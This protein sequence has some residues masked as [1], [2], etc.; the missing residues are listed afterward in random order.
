MPKTTL[1]LIAVVAL[2]GALVGCGDSRTIHGPGDK[3]L[4]VTIPSDVEVRQGAGQA[5]TIQ[6]D[7]HNFAGPI[8]VTVGN[9]PDGTSLDEQTK[10]VE[11]DQAVFM[12]S[13]D[14]DA[15]L[16][17]DHAVTVDIQAPHGMTYQGS[18]PLTVT[19]P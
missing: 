14:S 9:L 3:S 17:R 10:T 16:V 11:T 8:D 1:P 2:A 15:D 19:L 13:A 18:F 12:L 4:D 6:L 5:V 7:R